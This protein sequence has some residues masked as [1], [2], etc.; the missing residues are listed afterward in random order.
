VSAGGCW[1]DLCAFIHGWVELS[2]AEKSS[3]AGRPL[4]LNQDS[5]SA[6][7]A[8]LRGML[9]AKPTKLRSTVA[10]R[11]K[12]SRDPS[13]ALAWNSTERET[14]SRAWIDRHAK[15]DTA[16]AAAAGP[17]AAGGSDGGEGGLEL[18]QIGDMKVEI[19]T[20]SERA[21]PK[22]EG[23]Q[24]KAPKGKKSGSAVAERTAAAEPPQRRQWCAAFTSI[25]ILCLS[26]VLADQPPARRQQAFEREGEQ[27]PCCVLCFTPYPEACRLQ[28]E[29]AFC[30]QVPPL[31]HKY[32]YPNRLL[33]D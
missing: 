30:S 10:A 19:R 9:S 3:L 31:Q 17:A 7:A 28:Y 12:S 21:E 25:L 15:T 2:P 1:R 4:S 24:R 33:V 8:C 26:P 27:R 5:Y 6:S 22:Q 32:F 14:D 11:T 29:S 13:Q 16:N 23:A 20:W 18:A